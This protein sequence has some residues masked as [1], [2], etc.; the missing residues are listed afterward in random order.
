MC[1]LP[2]SGKTTLATALALRLGWRYIS[3]DAINTERGVGLEGRAITAAEWD[4]SYAD[5]YA[6]IETCL[7]DRRSVIYD[8]TNFARSQRDYL[9]V[10]ATEYG[11]RSYV[12][13]MR[14]PEADARR[15]WLLNRKTLERRDVRDEDFTYVLQHF[16][17]PTCDEQRIICD[18]ARAVGELVESVLSRVLADSSVV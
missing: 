16:E 11:V 13:H 8:E 9:W 18:S 15:R 3:L 10:I 14:I 7:R 4:R 6:R 17:P 5:V 2:F 1:G 12:V